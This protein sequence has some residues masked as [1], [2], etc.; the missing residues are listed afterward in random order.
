LCQFVL[1]PSSPFELRDLL[2]PP[3]SP[4]LAPIIFPRPYLIA[5]PQWRN[6]PTPLFFAPREEEDSPQ[7]CAFV[8]RI[9][10]WF[11]LGEKGNL[12][13]GAFRNLAA[14]RLS[15]PLS[16]SNAR[17]SN[18]GER[19]KQSKQVR[20]SPR[21]SSL[22]GGGRILSCLTRKSF[23]GDLTLNE[24]DGRSRYTAKKGL[25]QHP[26]ARAKRARDCSSRR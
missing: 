16:S 14:T 18:Q 17:S 1:L 20:V 15:H 9:L 24:R 23:V 19:I 10:H 4:P 26:S 13:Q 8:I 5:L 12:C 11:F 25:L 21:P 6:P 22:S 2:T 7:P 3:L